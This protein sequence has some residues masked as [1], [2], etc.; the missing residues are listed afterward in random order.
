MKKNSLPIQILIGIIFFTVV[1]VGTLAAISVLSYGNAQRS[2]FDRFANLL[3]A[4]QQNQRQLLNSA[5]S[6]KVEALTDLMARSS[7]EPMTAFDTDV[8]ENLINQAKSDGDIDNV[9]FLSSDGSLFAGIKETTENKNTINKEIADPDIG[10]V[11]SVEVTFDSS[12]VVSSTRDL[13]KRI[14]SH[15]TEAEQAMAYTQRAVVNR[16]ILFSV[17]G[18]ILFCLLTYLRLNHIIIRPINR[19]VRL[20]E[21]IAKGDYIK[22]LS[23]E[24]YRELDDLSKWI[25]TM[26]ES[27]QQIVKNIKVTSDDLST[28]SSSLA[29][30]SS[31][32]KS[33]VDNSSRNSK[34]VAESAEELSSNMN[35]VASA[36]ELL[37]DNINSAALSTEE[38]TTTIGN[39]AG[40]A[41]SAIGMTNNAVERSAKTS[42]I[43]DE[44][45]KA[46]D[47]IGK[48]VESISEISAQTN[49]LALNATIEAARAGDAGKGFAVVAKEIKDLATQTSEAT[50]D[51]KNKVSRIQGSTSGAVVEVAGILD[52]IVEVNDIVSIIETEVAEQSAASHEITKNVQRAVQVVNEVSENI[53]HSSKASSEIAVDIST[54]DLAASEISTSSTKVEDKAEA[55]N[56]LAER[57]QQMMVHFKV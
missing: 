40:H 19:M 12:S 28:S 49:L 8:L 56:H 11:G 26:A 22:R 23:S 57:L 38:M 46:A 30:I 34:S 1:L 24:K 39:I 41:N 54:V 18:I 47:A 3:K 21:H 53:T 13:Q 4:E 6:R 42:E 43:I 55:L 25:N 5:L 51:I 50:V 33:S 37:L 48:V 35:S 17:I 27:S 31:Q 32:L 44:L 52:I 36:T 2:Q 15:L 45:G 20:L 29:T 10:V 7:L 16:I 14:L 9:I